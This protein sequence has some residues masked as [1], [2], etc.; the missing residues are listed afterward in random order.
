MAEILAKIRKL[1]EPESANTDGGSRIVSVASR[2][3]P[4]LLHSEASH[5]HA[6][7]ITRQAFFMENSSQE[8]PKAE[9][10]TDDLGFM[11]STSH[12][13]SVLKIIPVVAAIIAIA[14]IIILA[15]DHEHYGSCTIAVAIIFHAF[16]KR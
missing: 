15:L 1:F 3:S 4:F 11:L 14:I 2:R 7:Q 6:C 16:Y 9:A 8:K 10:K 13:M 5:A 12:C